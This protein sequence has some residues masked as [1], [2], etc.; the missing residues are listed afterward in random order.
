VFRLSSYG[1]LDLI[2]KELGTGLIDVGV[3]EGSHVA[4][5]SE[6]RIEW[7]VSNLAIMG[8]RAVVLPRGSTADAQDLEHI[9]NH[10]DSTTVIVEDE[11]TLA[12]IESFE[13]P[14]V[15]RFIVIDE[16]YRGN[17]EILKLSEVIDLGRKK[18]I[19]GDKRFAERSE[20][21]TAD[22]ILTIIYT[23]GQS[24]TPKGVVLTHGN[25]MHN[26]RIV[27]GLVELTSDD[28]I[29][30]IMPPWHALEMIVEYSAITNGT[31]LYYTQLRSGKP[32]PSI[33]REN[34]RIVKPTFLVAV[35][36]IFASVYDSFYRKLRDAEKEQPGT[37]EQFEKFYRKLALP[38]ALAKARRRRELPLFST[39]GMK[40]RILST[41]K[42]EP[43]V[44]LVEKNLPMVVD[45]HLR[46]MGHLYKE[47]DAKA[48]SLLREALGGELRAA[49]SGG[50]AMPEEIEN[51]LLAA[52]ITVFQAYGL[53]ETSPVVTLRHF[54]RNALYTIG[55]PIPDTEARIIDP[56]SINYRRIGMY[57]DLDISQAKDVGSGEDGFILV[58]GEQVFREY[59]KDEKA[60][61]RVKTD[62]GWF[63]TGDIGRMTIY[64]DLQFVDR[65]GDFIKTLSGEK[66]PS[67]PI[68]QALE[69]SPY[70]SQAMIVG[71]A[72]PMVGALIVPDLDYFE[73]EGF[74]NAFE[75]IQANPEALNIIREELSARVNISTGFR[76]FEMIGP[77]TLLP[78]LPMT[79]TLKVKKREAKRLRAEQIEEMYA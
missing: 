76:S 55:R 79:Q 8:A 57:E 40:D 62:D 5:I 59:Y 73:E 68:E 23:S 25:I 67:L 6:N 27:P 60:T 29:L 1:Q 75:T 13:A 11:S 44:Q 63:N 65:E 26:L 72:R 17:R 66:I 2:V 48:F 77:F 64:G 69:R 19:E 39:P 24:G 7:L 46:R 9:I 71:Q 53:T 43:I 30:S 56:E 31:S 70:I 51:L 49:I 12:K 14:K 54:D 21:I 58:K 47:G 28:R 20:R 18:L 42:S 61:R 22:D 4:L 52:G 33:M 37:R 38:Y 41:M 32:V 45:G 35:P 3:E 74:V 10:S 36:Q 34:L 15:E 16:R 78:E 50:A